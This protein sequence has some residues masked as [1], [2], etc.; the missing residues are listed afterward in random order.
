LK[1]ALNTIKQIK[2]IKHRS[3]QTIGFKSVFAVYPLNT[4]L[5]GSSTKID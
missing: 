4:Q 1:V 3:G 5:E 2:P